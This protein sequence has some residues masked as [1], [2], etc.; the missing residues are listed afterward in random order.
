MAQ[1]EVTTKL[2]ETKPSEIIYANGFDLAL[3]FADMS[4]TFQLDGHRFLTV[5][6]S[7]VVARTLS[8]ALREFLDDYETKL[9]VPIKS[10]DEI[11]AILQASSK[12]VT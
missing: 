7:H 2:P 8:G 3:G 5:K 9:G 11:A 10:V 4:V 12:V 6:C 1:S